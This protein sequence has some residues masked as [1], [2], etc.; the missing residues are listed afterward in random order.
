M[1]GYQTANIRIGAT[2]GA[3]ESTL[4][5]DN[6]FD[7]GGNTFAFGNPFDAGKIRLSTPPRPRTIGLQLVWRS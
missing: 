7:E 6:V 4:S 3:W 1:G 5:V 2:R